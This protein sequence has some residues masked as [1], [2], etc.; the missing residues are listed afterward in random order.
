MTVH[1]ILGM[2]LEL[3]LSVIVRLTAGFFSRRSSATLC[4]D[5]YQESSELRSVLSNRE[6]P[7]L[8][9]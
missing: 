7:H 9:I 6:K 4:S 1:Q 8:L 3:L 5:C 2:F